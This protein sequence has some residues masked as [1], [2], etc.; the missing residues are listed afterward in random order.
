M[1]ISIDIHLYIYMYRYMYIYMTQS[2]FSF[3]LNL[4]VFCLIW[5]C[6]TFL[7][8]NYEFFHLKVK[9]HDL[10]I[11]QSYKKR[12]RWYPKRHEIP[13]LE[14]ALLSFNL[15]WMFQ[16]RLCIWAYHGP[17]LPMAWR[18]FLGIATHT[19]PSAAFPADSSATAE[20]APGRPLD[21]GVPLL[22]ISNVHG[23]V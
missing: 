5:L 21:R 12:V 23:Q 7:Y 9:W 17:I 6:Q 13:Y 15:A 10:W 2:F 20:F 1:Y 4:R 22:E 14:T 11:S 19:C 18:L 8:S 16:R 3:V